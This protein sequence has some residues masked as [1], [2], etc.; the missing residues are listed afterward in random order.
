MQTTWVRFRCS[1]FLGICAN[2]G[3]RSCESLWYVWAM[4]KKR[5]RNTL[6]L[7]YVAY[8][9]HE[10]TYTFFFQALRPNWLE[11]TNLQ[12]WLLSCSVRS[13]GLQPSSLPKTKRMN[14]LSGTHRCSQKNGMTSFELRL[15]GTHKVWAFLQLLTLMLAS[16]RSMLEDM[17]K[18]PGILDDVLSG[19]LEFRLTIVLLSLP[20]VSPRLEA[21]PLLEPRHG[22]WPA[23]NVNTFVS[24][25]WRITGMVDMGGC[26]RCID[27]QVIFGETLRLFVC[28]R[29]ASREG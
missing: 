7:P 13:S 15:P 21:G 12:C 4:S 19:T 17:L 6:S 24:S 14:A 22:S 20:S 29:K 25:F 18:L 11:A 3:R 1:G 2:R 28:N 23:S 5:N 8:I 27:C 9:Q 26:R 10:Y 16:C